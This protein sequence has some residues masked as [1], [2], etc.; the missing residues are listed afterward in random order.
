[1]QEEFR[2]GLSVVVPLFNEEES[3][4][5]LYKAIVDATKDIGV[6]VELIFVDDGSRDNTFGVAEKLALA[7]SRLRVVKFRRN[8][9]QTPAMAAGIDLARGALIITMDGDL[10][11]DPR[12]IPNFVDK[13]NEGFDIV[14]GWRHDRQDKLISRKIPS[15]IANWIIGKVTGVPIKDNGCSL[16]AF[17]ADVIKTVPLYSEMHRFIPAMASIAGP[18]LAEIK[19]RHHARQFGESKYGLSRVYKVLLDLLTIKTISGF[20]ARPLSWF[21]A[22]ALPFIILSSIMAV[23]VT[24]RLIATESLSL[25]ISGSA[26]FFATLSIFLIFGGALG[27]LI[28]ATGDQNVSKYSLLTATELGANPDS[29]PA[30]AGEPPDNE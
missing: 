22:L 28:N 6:E 3:V 11:N 21:A 16:K 18:R 17:R 23:W 8:Y 24:S 9:G 13:I 7:D 12:D 14:V 25:P 26:L 15:R 4:P 29:S 10:Q 30:S 27:E 1:M 20:S 19:V 5:L 2:P